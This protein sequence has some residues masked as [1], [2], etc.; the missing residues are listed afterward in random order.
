MLQ[1]YKLKNGLRV[2][3]APSEG[4]DTV[5]VLVLVRVGSRYE[6]KALNGAS[7]FIE[8]LLFKGTKKRPTAQHI[9]R[10]LDALGAE[11]NA[12]TNKHITGYYIKW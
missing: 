10:A 7:H 3:L 9:S 5:T 1:E 4:T 8:H 2:M 11:F 12:Y 6:Y